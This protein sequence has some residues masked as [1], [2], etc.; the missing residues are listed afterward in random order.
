MIVTQYAGLS[1]AVFGAIGTTILF[2]SSYALQP[3]EG[4]VLGSEFLTEQN[5][6]IQLDNLHRLR[7]QK[8]GFA[9]LCFSFI[10]QAIAC[11]L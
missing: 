7:R 9:F 3:L 2:F 6:R 8:I 5:N 10:I 4:S 11:F 1:S